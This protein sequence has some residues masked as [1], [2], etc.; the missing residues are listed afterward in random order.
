LARFHGTW[1]S[2]A[3][4]SWQGRRVVVFLKP[5]NVGETMENTGLYT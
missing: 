1:T 2:W 4:V 5:K 3:S